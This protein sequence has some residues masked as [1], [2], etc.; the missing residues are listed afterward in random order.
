MLYTRS[1]CYKLTFRGLMMPYRVMDLSGCYIV[2]RRVAWRY[3]AITS[4]DNWSVNSCKNATGYKQ[5]RT[6]SLI[7]LNNDVWSHKIYS[8]SL[9]DI[10]NLKH[11]N[12]VIMTTMASQITSFTVGSSTVYSDADQ[13]KHQSSASLAFVWGFNRDRWIPRTNDQ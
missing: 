8:K 2:W 6:I 10:E 4:T 7:L 13:R 1:V 11:Y 12:G 9:I 3:H 5:S